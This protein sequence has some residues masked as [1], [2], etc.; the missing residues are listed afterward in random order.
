MEAT[1]EEIQRIL[2]EKNY[3]KVFDLDPKC[4]IEDIKNRYRVLAK[5]YHP[6]R[7][8]H[9]KATEV[10]QKINKIYKTLID[11]TERA[12][13][14]A[15][16][17]DEGREQ[18][19]QR[20]PQRRR[21]TFTDVLSIFLGFPVNLYDNREG[22]N[23][24]QGPKLNFVNVLIFLV[25]GLLPFIAQIRTVKQYFINPVT[26]D[27]LKGILLFN[28]G[29]EEN[30]IEK[31]SSKYGVKYYVPYSW[32]IEKLGRRNYV[33]HISDFDNVADQLYQEELRINCELEK[34]QFNGK[35]G[36]HCSKM[37]RILKE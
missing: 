35:E 16:G 26:R 21:M 17:S 25:L 33:K 29:Q 37:K 36:K 27:N 5:L 30:Y 2:S 31:Y 20:R 10:F 12:K 6:D 22:D 7:C 13:Y 8:E 14:D 23:G 1:D 24:Q 9:E 11:P 34:N 32:I 19:R 15:I 4:S 28:K 18:Q 3:Y